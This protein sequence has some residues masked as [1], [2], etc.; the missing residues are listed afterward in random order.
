MTKSQVLS[1][2]V[3][4]Y[5]RVFAD[6][7]AS[8]IVGGGIRGRTWT[9]PIYVYMMTQYGEITILSLTLLIYLLVGF[10]LLYTFLTARETSRSLEH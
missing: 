4:T 7:G 3:L 9:F 6:F 8:L 2:L 5:A 10:V 1:G